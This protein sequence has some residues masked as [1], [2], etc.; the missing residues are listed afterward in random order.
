MVYGTLLPLPASMNPDLILS[1]LDIVPS[2]VT[3]D[4][5]GDLRSAGFDVET[6]KRENQPFAS[7]EWLVPTA[8]TLVITQYAS[9]LVREAAKEHYPVLK[10]AL[11]RL[12]GRTT[13]P[14]VETPL[15]RVSTSGKDITG[16]PP[17]VFSV[18]TTLRDEKRVR[19][20]FTHD[21]D[22]DQHEA[23]VS[24]L[25]GAIDRY[26]SGAPDDP[27]T[28]QIPAEGTWPKNDL[29]LRYSTQPGYGWR[30]VDLRPPQLS[31]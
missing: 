11:L 14:E 22:A 28:A 3:D 23:A 16:E 4:V 17:V 1:R 13:G 26:A 19:F 24:D 20:M 10:R 21:L 12:V 15:S 8:I 18:L 30:I 25:L 2:E 27:I 7:L 6:H 9:G 5:V 29:V 31:S